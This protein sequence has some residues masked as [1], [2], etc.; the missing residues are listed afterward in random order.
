MRFR[1]SEQQ[2][3][4]VRRLTDSSFV[5]GIDSPL[6]I[7]CIILFAENNHPARPSLLASY[8][9][10][11]SQ[12]EL[13]HQTAGALTLSSQYLRRALLAVRERG[14]KG[15]FTVHTHPLADKVV[16]FSP[17]DDAKRSG[18]NVESL[19]SPANR[20]VRKYSLGKT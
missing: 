9:L 12:E 15:F 10:A 6:E 11:P 1:A 19:R 7:G 13:L 5:R 20:P 14:L 4:Q 17:Y 3:D 2:W 18:T 8:V 16:S